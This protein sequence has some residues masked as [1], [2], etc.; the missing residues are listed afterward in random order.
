MAVKPA[1]IIGLVL[2][3]IATG[4]GGE[5]TAAGDET[6]PQQGQAATS[7]GVTVSGRCSAAM[8]TYHEKLLSDQGD[9]DEGP[10]QV[11]TLKACKSKAEWVAAV[12]PYSEGEGCIVCAEV[13]KVYAA[14]CGGREDLPACMN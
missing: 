9:L 13:E 7:D 4:C 2:A 6:E 5:G 12:E 10:L 3:L 11:A 8:A 1:A 14:M